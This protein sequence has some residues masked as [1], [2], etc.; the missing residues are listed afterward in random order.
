[1]QS[2]EGEWYEA[3]ANTR[4]EKD[5]NAMR[6]WFANDIVPDE[7]EQF[8]FDTE[9]LREVSSRSGAVYKGVICLVLASGNGA[10]DFHRDCEISLSMISTNEVDDHH[11]FPRDY[12][13]NHKG[14]E[15]KT[16]VYL[17]EL[18]RVRDSASILASHLIPVGE[19]SPLF[20]NDY[21]EFLKQRSALIVAEIE[22]VTGG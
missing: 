11:I 14:V 20:A 12:L 13:E 6:E 9:I 4:A 19:N 18:N 15:K 21:E 16:S 2:I 7:I 17:E 5:V 22:R 8:R 3:A 1:L 10:R